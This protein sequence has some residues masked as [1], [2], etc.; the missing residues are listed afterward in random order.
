[1]FERYLCFRNRSF[2]L[3]SFDQILFFFFFDKF[4]R[5]H[6][7]SRRVQYLTGKKHVPNNEDLS[8][9]KTENPKLDAE[10]KRVHCTVKEEARK[11]YKLRQ[12]GP[13]VV[14]YESGETD[15][16]MSW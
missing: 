2:S 16:E 12:T 5:L 10:C 3:F 15:G 13:S 8:G 11:R 14:V 9:S 6:S 4:I 1:M 7:L